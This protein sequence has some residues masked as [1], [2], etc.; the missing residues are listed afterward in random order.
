MQKPAK[1]DPFAIRMNKNILFILLSV[2]L[3]ACAHSP[4]PASNALHVAPRDDA[5]V[6][7]PDWGLAP[8]QVLPENHLALTKG[9]APSLLNEMD[10]FWV[11]MGISFT[12]STQK[13][14]VYRL[15]TAVYFPLGKAMSTEPL[16]Q[17]MALLAEH[18]KAQ[19]ALELYVIGHTDA[20]GSEMRNQLLSLERAAWVKSH[21]TH[22]G[23]AGRQIHLQALDSQSPAC[24]RQNLSV[25]ACNRRVE[26]ELWIQE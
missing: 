17:W 20:S 26:F 25:N 3:M 21:F 15:Q 6:S 5:E 13:R 18:M 2:L 19:Q 4:Y 8:N 14:V 9:G 22:L 1:M 10:S 12:R 11:D 7:Q 23:V 24:M 16:P